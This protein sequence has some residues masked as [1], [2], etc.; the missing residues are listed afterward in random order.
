MCWSLGGVNTQRSV[1]IASGSDATTCARTPISRCRHK[2]RL[3]GAE[4]REAAWKPVFPDGLCV[5]LDA[6]ALVAM[7][8]AA[9]ASLLSHVR[10]LAAAAEAPHCV[11]A[12]AAPPADLAGLQ[13]AATAGHAH[14]AENWRLWQ[15]ASGLAREL[16]DR[17]MEARP[18]P[19][20]PPAVVQHALV[21]AR[22]AAP[23][24]RLVYLC[25][26]S[27]GGCV[28]GQVAGG[29][30]LGASFTMLRACSMLQPVVPARR[31]L[32]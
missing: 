19:E 25:S 8:P 1:L 5:V 29:E 28:F 9:L 6:P 14:A 24:C 7:Q 26:G 2:R 17:E 32:W 21:M 15:A 31:S 22:N 18:H 20:G 16:G 3:H 10:Q 12:V 30:Q 27:Q 23:W 4:W 13:A 11:F